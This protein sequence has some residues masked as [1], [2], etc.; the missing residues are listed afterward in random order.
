MYLCY[1]TVLY[2]SWERAFDNV[3]KTC[4]PIPL[5]TIEQINMFKLKLLIS[6]SDKSNRLCKMM[7]RKPLISNF[8]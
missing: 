6:N 3:V 4:S 8:G 5:H 1:V 7:N 2:I